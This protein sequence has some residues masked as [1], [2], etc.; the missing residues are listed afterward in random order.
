MIM[1]IREDLIVSGSSVVTKVHGLRSSYYG[2]ARYL[3]PGLQPEDVVERAHG[4]VHAPRD[5]GKTPALGGH[6]S[7]A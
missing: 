4:Y 1:I 7:S 3:W 5:T 2:A 6:L